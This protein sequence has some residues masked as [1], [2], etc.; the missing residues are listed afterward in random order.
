MYR[1]IRS[2]GPRIV[3]FSL[4]EV[5]SHRLID[6]RLSAANI[7]PFGE[8]KPSDL[9]ENDLLECFIELFFRETT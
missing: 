9:I 1:S 5:N 8:K 4:S 2:D 6:F 7:F 3:D